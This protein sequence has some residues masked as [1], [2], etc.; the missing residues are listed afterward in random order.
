MKKTLLA[1]SSLLFSA[2]L[3]MAEGGPGGGGPGPGPVPDPWVVS[4]A[5]IN[6]ANGTVK[7]GPSTLANT[8]VGTVNA[9]NGFYINGVKIN[10]VTSATAPVA[11]NVGI[12]VV[13]LNID[14]NFSVVSSNLALA[15]G[16][17]AYPSTVTGGAKG[18]GTI[19]ANGLFVGGVAVT[20][21]GITSLT[22]DVVATGPGAAAA[23][24]QPNV[25]TYA[26][27]QQIAAS[28]L[29]GNPTGS[30]A[31]G[32]EISLGTTLAFSGIAL[33]TVAM[34]GDLTTPA[35]SFVTTFNTVNTNVG[36]FGSATQVAQITVNGK[37]LTTAVSNVTVT[38]AIGSITGLGTGVATALGVNVG[39]AGSFVVNGGALGTPSSG[40]AT[41]L[42][43]TAAGL[44]AGNV[45]TNANLTGVITS[46]GNATSINSQTGTG[47][48]FVVDTGPTI[49]ALVVT[50]SFTATG[51]VTNADLA[52]SI[53]A[54]K[55]VGTDIATVGTLTAGTASTGFTINAANVTV[56]GQFPG[57][58]V[59][60]VANASGSPSATF[61]VMKADGTTITCSSGT[62]SAVGGVATSVGVGSTTVTSGT[63]N[64]I[65]TTGTG[66][67]ANVTIASL[68][69][70]GNGILVTGTTN[71]GIAVDVATAS[72]FYSAT[73]NKIVDSAVPYTAVPTPAFSA[74]PT[75]DFNTSAS[76]VPGVLTA[77]I[78]AM[79][80]SNMK[81]NQ[82][83]FIK[84]KQ[85][86]TGGRT[87]VFCSQF[88]FPNSTAPTLS[89][90]ANAVDYLIYTCETST[91]CPAS[92]NKNTGWLYMPGVFRPR[93]LPAN[94]NELLRVTG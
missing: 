43:G 42:T 40:V 76:F 90:G 57:T 17:V 24:I 41:N 93:G 56:S 2:T 30:L 38:P 34:S 5:N 67:L 29:F 55:L 31:N 91:R 46:V 4:G 70:Q 88:L 61:G 54:S 52:G 71:A 49:S 82:G 84:L 32:Q 66:T 1:I 53:A 74:T 39:T 81:A 47:T 79:T 10:G 26:K 80:C 13:S 63:N 36:T 62:C 37:G 8:G 48:K 11:Y 68:L 44:T 22:T 19:N 77:N 3:V 27:F 7:V 16:G 12:G 33:Q 92:L 64:N 28:R 78:T 89:T 25:V 18:A 45:T 51:L 15:A 75:F 21:A 94:D 6:Y 73:A 50:G 58:A 65:L 69:T 87:A 9:S 35:N 20:G 85:D 59:A 60:V 72:N 23:T 14:T 86:G 83:G